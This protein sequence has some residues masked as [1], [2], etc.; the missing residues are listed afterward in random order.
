VDGIRT[1]TSR[2]N[3][4]KGVAER[5]S[6]SFSGFPFSDERHLDYLTTMGYRRGTGRV[7]IFMRK[8]SLGC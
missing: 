1:A 3:K 7:D 8:R 6:G 4:L 2:K 5:I